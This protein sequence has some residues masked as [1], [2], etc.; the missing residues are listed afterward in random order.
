MSR[1]QFIISGNI[2]GDRVRLGRA[3]HNPPLTQE[4]LAMK[5]QFLGYD[6]TP[7]ILS[8]IEKKQRH[9]C[10]AE[11]KILAQAL[12]VSMDWLCGD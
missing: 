10:D 12:G 9:V 7:L 2:C 8:R 6:I 4:Q 3:M 5:I 1:K 11:L